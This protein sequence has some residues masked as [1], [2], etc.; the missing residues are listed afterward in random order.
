MDARDTTGRE[1]GQA[2]PAA[3]GQ[4]HV[5]F[6]LGKFALALPLEAVQ[7]VE[8]PG[9]FTAVPYAAPWL[10][11]VA[12]VRGTVVSVVDL[13]AFAGAE[14]AGRSPGARLLVTSAA[15]IT[16]ALLVDAVGKIVYLPRDL[17]AAPTSGG[18]L[19]AWWR[20]AHTVDDEVVAVVD[21]RRLFGAPAFRAYQV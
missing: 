16:A 11:G 5:L 21:P 8:R 6:R 20:G 4:P 10:R 17:A 3:P 2:A 9:R 15:G 7:A 14:P 13:G 1:Q 19:D 18:P 12:A